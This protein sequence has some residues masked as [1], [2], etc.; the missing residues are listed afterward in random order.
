MIAQLTRNERQLAILISLAVAVCG[1]AF[2]IL[3][4]NDPLGIHGALF[5]IAGL[6]AIFWV[7]TG[8][9]A[10]E[11]PESRLALYYDDPTR[12]GIILAMIWAVFGLAVGDWVAWL[13]VNP[14]LTFDAGWSSFGRRPAGQ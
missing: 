7:G 12:V 14:D 10:P 8:Y 4:R 3:G 11:P 2:A 1:L 9:Y 13:L 5:M 6:L